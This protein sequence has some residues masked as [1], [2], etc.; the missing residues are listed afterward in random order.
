MS[1]ERHTA[2]DISYANS[3]ESMPGQTVVKLLENA[4]GRLTLIKRARG[5]QDEVARGR[6]FWQVIVERYGLSLNIVG[7]SI[8]QIP[9]TGPIILIAN[10]PYG[11]LDGLMLG[12]IRRW[13]GKIFAFWPIQCFKNLMN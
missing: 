6:D 3:A 8:D 13:C 9:K 4:T 2:Q 5:Y 11:I 12:H 7:G 10:H 1:R